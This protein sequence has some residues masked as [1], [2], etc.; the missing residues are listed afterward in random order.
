MIW[1]RTGLVLTEIGNV[2]QIVVYSE[3]PWFTA[4]FGK[5]LSFDKTARL[6]FQFLFGLSIDHD[7]LFE[8]QLARI[9][10]EEQETTILCCLIIGGFRIDRQQIPIMK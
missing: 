1:H 4:C 8:D 5:N 10:I 7:A 9:G 6:L 2:D 3:E